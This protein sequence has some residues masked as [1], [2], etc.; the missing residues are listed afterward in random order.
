MRHF[1]KPMK[2]HVSCIRIAVFLIGLAHVVHA[3]RESWYEAEAATGDPLL[4]INRV[5][6]GYEHKEGG[7]HSEKFIPN[8]RLLL[9]GKTGRND[10]SIGVEMPYL[11]ND[12]DNAASE[13]GIGDFKIRLGHNWLE[14]ET[15]LVSSYF[16]TE[17]D[18]ASDDV[19]A[20]AN[21]RT[22]FAFGTGFIRNF[23]DGWAVGSAVQFGWSHDAGTT[24][25]HKGEWE[26][27]VGARKTFCE[28]WSIT[29]I[30]KATVNVVGDDT[31]NSSI[32]PVL[33]WDF[34]FLDLE[35]LSSYI[36]CEV[37][38]ESGREDYTLKTGLA[39][40]F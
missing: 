4:S 13:E 23:G 17:F 6:L 27:R 14:D 10:W 16:E 35:K 29:A 3:E 2:T 33:A 36:S 15:W 24:N 31:Y 9:G 38:L 37:P 8:G 26:I 25:G 28:S 34:G 5:G 22:Q 1:F 39:W 32:E 21:Q 7:G 40:V 12:P 18:T 30:Y 11:I 20:I 19:Q